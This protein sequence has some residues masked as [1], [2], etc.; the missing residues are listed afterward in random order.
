MVTTALSPA[1]VAEYYKHRLPSLPQQDKEWRCPCPIHGGKR[2]SFAVQ[3]DTGR[4]FCHSQCGRGGDAYELEQTLS[5]LSTFPESLEAVNAIVG[6]AASSSSAGPG[7]VEDT[8]YDYLDETGAVLFQVVRFFPKGFLPRRPDGRGGWTYNLHGVRRVPYRLPE[9]LLKKTV[10]VTE[11]EK[12]SDALWKLGLPATTAPGG[13]GKWREEYSETLAGRQVV[14]FPDADERGRRDAVQKARSLL[15]KA[16][17]VK[18]VELPGLPEKGDISDWLSAGG[19]RSE[20][21][22]LV[23]AAPKLNAEALNELERRWFGPEMITGAEQKR[24]SESTSRA[25]DT[26][27]GVPAFPEMA[28]RGLF[29]TYRA[30]MDATTEAADVAHFAALWVACAA[31]LGRRV[32][33][34]SGTLIYPNAYLAF[35]GATGDKKTT[36]QRRIFSLGLPESVRIVP[37]VGTP[38]GFAKHLKENSGEG[39]SWLFFWEELSSLLAR[40]RWAGSTV[41]EFVT[42]TFDCPDQWA[43]RYATNPVELEEPT[44][45]ILAG[46]TPEWFWKQ[47]REDD[48]Y[49]GFGNRFLWFTGAKK[50]PLPEPDEPRQ[51][52]LRQL[53]A[54]I[55]ELSQ[56][57]PVRAEFTPEARALWAEFYRDW[58]SRERPGLEGA[59]LKRI[60]VYVRKLA[61]VYAALEKTLPR[62]EAEQLAAAIAVGSYAACC[63]RFLIGQ[64]GRNTRGDAGLERRFVEW[65]ERNPGAKVRYMQQTMSKYCESAEAFNRILRSLVQADRIREEKKPRRVFPAVD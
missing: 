38:E 15:A 1:E 43:L 8:Y 7:R 60:H 57:G 53:R 6:R 45:S 63:A 48:F 31:S 10:F 13:A 4:W 12:D 35:F 50:S 61:M 26:D 40:G 23:R 32:S 59:A 37:S 46:T 47:A 28:W 24:S 49:G 36:A 55:S 21:G 34:F 41:L 20:L 19:T 52:A 54:S 65:V 14:I 2:D 9:I 5:G 64:R 58:E 62:I 16:E 25:D 11:G 44:P 17:A 27:D 22:E 56:I 42:E 39:L 30:A 3:A 51:E 18:V 29:G 33:M